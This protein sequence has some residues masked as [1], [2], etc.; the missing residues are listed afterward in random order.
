MDRVV[1]LVLLTLFILSLAI[2]AEACY[3]EASN[4]GTIVIRDN[5]F[6]HP[7][8]CTCG[9]RSDL[10]RWVFHARLYPATLPS[11]VLSALVEDKVYPDPYAG[12]NL[13]S[14]PGATYPV[15]EDFSNI[16]M[17]PASPFRQSWWYRTEFKRP[18]EYSGKTIKSCRSLAGQL[19][20]PCCLGKRAR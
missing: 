12:T 9:R 20:F 5:W 6:I 10:D 16:P 13:R 8:R 18:A 19:F 2:T 7:S 11:T 14:I 1:S 15:F 3:Q 17:P 4:P